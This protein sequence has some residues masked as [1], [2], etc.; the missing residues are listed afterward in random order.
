MK[1]LTKKFY[2]ILP[3]KREVFSFI[4]YFWTPPHSLYKHLHFRGPFIVK[5]EEGKR[6]NFYHN[7][8]EI[9]NDI[10]WK[11]LT[12][13]WEKISMKL[14]LAL[15]KQ[16]TVVID[17]G[18]NTGVYSLVAKTVN[19]KTQV[20]AFEPIKR[21]FLELKGNCE[22]N[23][24]D[25]VCVE[26]ALSNKEGEQLIYE[27]E[28]PHLNAATLNQQTAELYSH[29]T[30]NK[31]TTIKTTTLDSFIR[32]NNLRGIDLVKI[33]VETHEP[34]VI[35]GFREFLPQHKPSFLIEVLMDEVGT[36]LQKYFDP[37][38]Y[39]YFNIDDQ[40]GVIKQE[41]SIHKS[42][43][44]NWLVCSEE[45]AAKIGLIKNDEYRN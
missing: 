19:P 10:F 15:C 29:G 30:L 21:V 44:F 4:K 26:K 34:E 2:E 3:F 17:I 31:A 45:I 42:D 23:K 11:G 22:L 14:W 12:K 43:Y 20:Y 41:K 40:K 36:R 13:G 9:E 35:D 28:E 24:Y 38:G 18:A 33:D 32:I 39:L 16:S 27:N 37:L 7:G 5:I 1:N 6:F 25:I 8:T